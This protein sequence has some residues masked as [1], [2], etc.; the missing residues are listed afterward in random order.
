MRLADVVNDDPFLVQI[1][2]TTT[3]VSPAFVPEGLTPQTDD[4]LLVEEVDRQLIV[5]ALMTEWE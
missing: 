4:I 3:Q 1:R 2:G 5:V